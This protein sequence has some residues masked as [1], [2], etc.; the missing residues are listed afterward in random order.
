MAER[1]RRVAWTEFAQIG[2]DDTLEYIGEDSPD[3]AGRSLDVVL[4]TA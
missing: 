2:L 4:D 1:S 3:A